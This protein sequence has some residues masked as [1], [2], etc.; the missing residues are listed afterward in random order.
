MKTTIFKIDGMNCEACANTIKTL[1]EKELGV[2][3]AWV[4]FADC[5]ARVL[6][7]PQAVQ[8]DRLVDVIQGK[9]FRVVSRETADGSPR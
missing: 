6:F 7:D 2:R 4:S 1:I 9:R 3:M 8:E 5:Q